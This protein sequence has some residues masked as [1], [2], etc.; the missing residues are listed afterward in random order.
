MDFLVVF[1]AVFL[2]V[3]FADFLVVFL[4]VFFAGDPPSAASLARR[5][6]SSSLAR[7][8]VMV[9]GL[10]PLRSEAL[11]V[12][13]VTYGPKRPS[14]TDIG[15]PETSLSPSIFS[16]GCAAARPRRFGSA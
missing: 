11:V 5:S 13:S 2:A 10:S 6:E 3:F 1:L 12:P 16:G 4:V 9:S 8:S 7:A 14:L 15:L